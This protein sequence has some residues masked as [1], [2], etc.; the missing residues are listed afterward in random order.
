MRVSQGMNEISLCAL[1]THGRPFAILLTIEM[2][3]PASEEIL[4]SFLRTYLQP[5]LSPATALFTSSHSSPKI[6]ET[7]H[8]STTC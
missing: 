7:F 3:G 6:E 4:C 8:D 2:V 5:G 1:C